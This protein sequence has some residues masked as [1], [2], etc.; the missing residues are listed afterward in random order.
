[1]TS[2]DRDTTPNATDTEQGGRDVNYLPLLLRHWKSITAVTVLGL[3][4]GLGV[5]YMVTPQYT[6]TARLFFTV[7]SG[8]TATDLNAGST[9]A[10]RQLSSYAKLA[11]EPLVLEPV[12]ESLPQETTLRDL[13]EKITTRVEPDTVMLSLSFED[14]DPQV[15]SD[16]ANAVA[17]QL[18]TTVQDLTPKR[19]GQDTVKATVTSYAQ[20]SSTPSSPVLPVLLAAGGLLGLFVAAA[21]WVSHEVFNTRVRHAEDLSRVTDLSLLGEVPLAKE[22]SGQGV[23][24]TADGDTPV[25]ESIRTLF[26]K[27]RFSTRKRDEANVLLFTSSVPGEGKSTLSANVAAAMAE[28]G[29]RTLLI[30]ADLRRPSVA[31]Y[32]GLEGAAGLTTILI[33]DATSQDVTQHIVGSDM[34]VITSGPVPPNALELLGSTDMA[35]FIESLKDHYDYV[36]IDAPPVL[37]VADSLMLSSYADAVVVVASAQGTRSHQLRKTLESLSS[38]HANV[39]GMALNKVRAV[40]GEGYYGQYTYA[41]KGVD[42]V[43]PH[44]ATERKTES[45]RHVGPH[46]KAVTA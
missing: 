20:A 30:D 21:F 26:T 6:S 10:E 44:P 32:L 22:G 9:F 12:R 18:A 17:S 13:Q 25:A 46:E 3:L 31:E 38:V 15:A 29:F 41:T 39:V 35:T 43:P 16:L 8:E 28:G 23:F 27:L 1:M 42:G 45:E 36:V 40:K 33:G 5:T 7:Q 14:R 37:P 4:V 19:D 24:V 11:K 34:D 2:A